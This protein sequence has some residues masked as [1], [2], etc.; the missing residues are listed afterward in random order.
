MYWTIPYGM[1]TIT[2]KGKSSPF[3]TYKGMKAQKAQWS[4]M[5]KCTVSGINSTALSKVCAYVY[6]LTVKHEWSSP[7]CCARY[8]WLYSALWFFFSPGTKIKYVDY[9][10]KSDC[11]IFEHY[12]THITILQVS[13]WKGWQKNTFRSL[14]SWLTFRSLCFIRVKWTQTD[15]YRHKK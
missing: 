1:S 15:D 11:M 6:T 9:W 8:E 12:Y 13:K 14:Y 10:P 2:T 5:Y 3:N 4:T 7:V